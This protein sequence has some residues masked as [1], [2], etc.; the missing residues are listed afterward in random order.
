MP[1]EVAGNLSW[2]VAVPEGLP[3]D[4]VAEAVHSR[5]ALVTVFPEG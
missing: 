5:L 2:V 4:A 3:D 1:K